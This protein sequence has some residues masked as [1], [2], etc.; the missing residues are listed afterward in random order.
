MLA[1]ATLF[2][3]VVLQTIEVTKYVYSFYTF[4]KKPSTMIDIEGQWDKKGCTYGRDASFETSEECEYPARCTVRKQFCVAPNCCIACNYP[5][6]PCG[7]C[8]PCDPTECCY[9]TPMRREV[10]GYKCQNKDGSSNKI[11]RTRRSVEEVLV[12][13]KPISDAPVENIPENDQTTQI[14]A[15]IAMGLEILP[16]RPI[17]EDEDNQ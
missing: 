8:P 10:K 13:P 9:T 15:Q 11:K 1:L 4:W 17:V 14:D 16:A 6:G 7:S 2:L 12:N 5:T 3:K